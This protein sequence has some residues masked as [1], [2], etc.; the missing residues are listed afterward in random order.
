MKKFS[1][2]I[3]FCVS[4]AVT[5]FAQSTTPE[6]VNKFIDLFNK[7]DFASIYNLYTDSFKQKITVD[8][9]QGLLTA[10]NNGVGENARFALS[11]SDGGTYTYIVTGDRASAKADLYVAG[12][13]LSGL[14]LSPYNG[15]LPNAQPAPI[16]KAP[17]T[18]KLANGQD[19]LIDSVIKKAW[20]ANHVGMAIAVVKNGQV[21]YYG[22][23]EAVKGSTAIPTATD[24]F[25]IGSITKTFTATI[26]AN[27]IKSEKIDPDK[28]FRSY[29][30][31]LFPGFKPGA[32]AITIKQLANHTSGLPSFP[33]FKPENVKPNEDPFNYFTKAD[34]ENYLKTQ[35]PDNANSG[36]TFA[37]SNLN[38]AIL[39]YIVAR[40]SNTSYDA[41]LNKYVINPLSLKS[42][43]LNTGKPIT[44]K[45]YRKGTEVP[46]LSLQAMAPAGMI[47]S[48]LEDLVL[49]AKANMKKQGMWALA[50]QPAFSNDKLQVGLSWIMQ[51]VKGKNITFHN[52]G[53]PGYRSFLGFD[54]NSQ[55]AVIILNN[56]GEDV[57]G[58]G[59]NLLGLL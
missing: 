28:D 58:L 35:L 33:P 9:S 11:S 25:E 34:L 53:T 15:P 57:T 14:R 5:A 52:G 37:Y 23:G 29:L 20:T 12:N 42:T 1:L 18:N 39:G 38:F 13:M 17:T 16:I 21:S 40:V 2:I 26:L 59:M 22:Y 55:T 31:N 30:P 32:N 4:F 24:I 46:Y 54:S 6:V 44:T 47:K 49:Y 41:L 50:Q 43:Y 10:V 56:S 51:K 36:K 45:G 19:K 3:T 8:A 7:K 48:N 27:L